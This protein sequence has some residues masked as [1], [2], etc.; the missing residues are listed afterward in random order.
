MAMN[1]E[2]AIT[3]VKQAIDQDKKKNFEEAARC[4]REAI[5]TFKT[6]AQFRGISKG[7]QQAIN[8]KCAQYEGR[9]KKLDKYLLANADFSQLFKDVVDH[10]KRPDSQ[11]SDSD[12]SICSEAWKG[13][14]NCL[15]YR[16]GIEAIEKGKKR[17]KKEQYSDALNFY[18]DGM[19]LLLEAAATNQD[20]PR[21]NENNEHLRF[22]CLLIHE[23]VEMIRNHL[24]I[25]LPLKPINN[26]LAPT[27]YSL[28]ES[29]GS[30]EPHIDQ[31][32]EEVEEN[33][34]C[35][36]ELGS[37]HSLNYHHKNSVISVI[38]N[39]NYNNQENQLEDQKLLQK[40]NSMASVTSHSQKNKSSLSLNNHHILNNS[41]NSDSKLRND[42]PQSI[43]LADLDGEMQI[44]NLSL[45]SSKSYSKSLQSIQSYNGS[46]KASPNN[47]SFYPDADCNI[48]ELT[49]HNSGLDLDLYLNG[50]GKTSPA[51]VSER[52][53]TTDQESDSGIS[54]QSPKAES[55]VQERSRH[56]SSEGIQS[57]QERSRHESF[58]V[59]ERSRHESFEV[60]ERSRHESFEIQSLQS[61]ED[62]AMLQVHRVEDGT[63]VIGSS[64]ARSSPPAVKISPSASMKRQ[65]KLKALADELTVLSQE[66]VV[67]TALII[68]PGT[69]NG[70]LG[71]K[72]GT[73]GT[74]VGTKTEAAVVPTRSLA[75]KPGYT[76]QDDDEN[77]NKGCYYFIACLDSLW[78]L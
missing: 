29:F 53:S 11:T 64:P 13:L 62:E 77:Y 34:L 57:L 54:D 51:G 23:R 60:Q 41:I 48:T 55:L 9:L 3:L 59:Q 44:S 4:Y 21:S 32:D 63:L 37:S 76:D 71:P 75:G 45:A 56:E 78:I 46:I 2:V 61:N 65:A 39:N 38:E 43:P 25:G 16:Q 22:K 50:N 68:K 72:T 26:S 15:L 58:E 73:L 28:K 67:D 12:G 66:D 31:N 6:V 36:S 49:V 27:E 69:K 24:D 47:S 35:S 1:I 8:L 5:I 19:A 20:D 40:S 30:P 7:V 14:K 42:T 17:D 33:I 70:T 74:K 10:H 52:S 18:E